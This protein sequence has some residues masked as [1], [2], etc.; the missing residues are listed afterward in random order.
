MTPIH[1]S[2]IQNVFFFSLGIKQIRFLSKWYVQTVNDE[3]KLSLLS[4]TADVVNNQ[5]NKETPTLVGDWNCL[6]IYITASFCAI[7]V[8]SILSS[9]IILIL[10]RGANLTL[11]NQYNKLWISECVFKRFLFFFFWTD[12]HKGFR[13]E[14]N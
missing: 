13:S 2:N 10:L 7:N 9:F 5:E 14:R 11:L 1:L 12:R 4:W 6:V 8:K 3:W